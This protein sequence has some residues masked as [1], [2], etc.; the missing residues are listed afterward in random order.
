MTAS[1]NGPADSLAIQTMQMQSWRAVA[2]ASKDRA[3][4]PSKAWLG[5]DRPLAPGLALRAPVHRI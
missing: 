5:L 3:W 1:V 2:V 4:Q